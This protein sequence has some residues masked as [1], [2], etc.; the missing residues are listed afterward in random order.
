MDAHHPD[1]TDVSRRAA[2]RGLAGGLVALLAAGKLGVGARPAFAQDGTPMAEHAADPSAGV[3]RR[4]LVAGVPD[5]APAHSMVMVHVAFA[6]DATT[7]PHTHPGG[8][9]IWIESG[10]I[11]YTPIGNSIQVMRAAVA[12]A[13]GPTEEIQPGTEVLVGPGDALFEAG[14]HGD[15][16][17]NAGEGEASLLVTY[18]V[19]ADQSLATITNEQ[20]T[21]TP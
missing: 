13:P 8:A 5:A 12:G 11:G 15:V 14:P 9:A 2:V 4:R 21:P 16:V 19:A 18:L 7:P 10:T 17:R 6:P 3:T 20:G 1:P